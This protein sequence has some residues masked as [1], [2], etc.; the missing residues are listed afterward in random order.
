MTDQMVTARARQHGAILN[1]ETSQL[2]LVISDGR[3]LFLEGVEAVKS[4]VRQ[5]REAH[6]FIVFVIIDSPVNKV[7]D[8]I[9]GHELSIIFLKL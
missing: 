8:V 4:A 6:V 7:G 1:P 5:A 3:G 9:C 2:L